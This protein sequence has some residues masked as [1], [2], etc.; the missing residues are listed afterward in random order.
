MGLLTWEFAVFV[1]AA[2]LLY[3]VLPRKVQ[4][5]VL[6]AANLAFYAFGGP[7]TLLYLG[8]TT[9]TTWLAGLILGRMNA[10]RKTGKGRKRLVTAAVLILN[11]GLLFA[12]KYW[13]TLAAELS[14]PGR[15]LPQLHL[16]MPLGLSFYIFQSAG[17]VI[18]CYRG[19]QPPEKNPAKYALFV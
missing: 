14:R 12:V 2:L 3:Y 5:I 11:F 9:L 16:L 19:K 13:N 10:D 7:Q 6:L 4:W 15:G 1:A 17:Y 8:F 18:D